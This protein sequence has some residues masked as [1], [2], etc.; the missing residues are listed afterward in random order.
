MR[1]EQFADSVGGAPP[2]WQGACGRAAPCGRGLAPGCICAAEAACSCCCAFLPGKAPDGAVRAAH[3]LLNLRT[4]SGCTAH[5]DG[6]E[7]EAPCF[8]R[9]MEPP[10][11][12]T[13]L[14]CWLGQWPV[15]VEHREEWSASCGYFLRN[16]GSQPVTSRKAAGTVAS[17]GV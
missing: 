9:S 8:A 6:T 4:T 13:A 17:D 1:A 12:P 15:F 2:W 14:S 11:S 7:E 5:R 10:H 16:E 3:R